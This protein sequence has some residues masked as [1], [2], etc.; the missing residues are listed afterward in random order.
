[1]VAG[2]SPNGNPI[3]S[4][5]HDHGAV[6]I[7]PYTLAEILRVLE[8]IGIDRWSVDLHHKYGVR[9]LMAFPLAVGSLSTGH[10]SS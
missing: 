6:A 5:V 8:P 2:L 10:A 9:D 4:S 1:M 3:A 7:G